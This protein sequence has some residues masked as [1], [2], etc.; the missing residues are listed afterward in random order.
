MVEWG[1]GIILKKH[2]CT[3]PGDTGN[4][5]I[6]WPAWGSKTTQ[7]YLCAHIEEE[8]GRYGKKEIVFYA[9]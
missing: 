5:L 8:R 1:P 7:L 4:V 9:Y 3:Q 6:H 2:T